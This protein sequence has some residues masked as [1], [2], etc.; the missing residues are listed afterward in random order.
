MFIYIYILLFQYHKNKIKPAKPGKIIKK[1]KMSYKRM[2]LKLRK[3]V[4]PKNFQ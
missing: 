3:M 1:I 4:F 2:I